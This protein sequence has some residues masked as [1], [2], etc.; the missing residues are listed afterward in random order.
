MP[1]D[2]LANAVNLGVSPQWATRTPA[3]TYAHA[4]TLYVCVIAVHA[5]VYA[6][7]YAGTHARTHIVSEYSPK[8]MS[9][10]FRHACRRVYRHVC[11]HVYRHFGCG[12]TFAYARCVCVCLRACARACA[13]VYDVHMCMMCTCELHLLD[14]MHGDSSV[15][16]TVLVCSRAARPPRP[17]LR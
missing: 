9:E 11:R 17:C 13:R 14:R 12:C 15:L 7:V 2:Y 4:H 8:K 5:H 16:A 3:R 6:H 10:V 1:V